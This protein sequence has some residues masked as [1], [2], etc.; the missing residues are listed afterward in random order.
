MPG[1]AKHTPAETTEW[2]AGNLR[3]A[4]RVSKV[5]VI[6]DQV[7]RVSRDKYAPF[8]AGIV[9]S[10]R[11]EANEV[12]PL[13]KSD[14]GVEIIANV[15]KESFWTGGALRLAHDN[16]IAT[17]AYGDLLGAIGLQDVRAFQP[18]EIEFVERG[19]RQHNRISRFERV[20]D[21]LY[22]VSRNSS[23]DLMVAMLNEYELTADHLRTARDRYGQFS[24]AVITNPYGKAT[25]TAEES[26]RTLSVEILKWGPFLGRLNK[27]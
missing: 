15:P 3:K 14:L 17:G 23:P 18:R 7:L 11:V 16:N 9:S 20:H 10:K 27:K 4:V 13:V 22:R 6:S 5:E 21:R 12:R 25:S 2:V 1:M 24:M 19:L 8:V 26:A